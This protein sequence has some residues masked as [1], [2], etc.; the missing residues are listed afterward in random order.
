MGFGQ[1]VVVVDACGQHG[2]NLTYILVRLDGCGKN[3]KVSFHF[4]LA[5]VDQIHTLDQKTAVFRLGNFSYLSLDVVHIVLFHRTAV[6]LIKV[7]ARST[8]INIEDMHIHIRV[9]VFQQHRLFCCIH[10]ADF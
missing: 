6:K 2:C 8:H 3:H 10:T 9:V 5:V 4:Y 7:L 1:E